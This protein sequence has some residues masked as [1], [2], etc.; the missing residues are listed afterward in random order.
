MIEDRELDA[1]R[2]Q[3]SGVA[4]PSAEFQRDVQRKVQ[5][6]IKRQDRRFVLG[7]ILTVFT[8]FGMLIFA[9]FMR[10]QSSWMGTGWAAG[11]FVLVFIS[12]GCRVW[13]L[14]R[15]WR[16]QSQ[17]TRAFAEL[18]Q[19]RVAARIRLLQIS[20][21]LSFGWIVFCAVLTAANWTTIGRD[22]E[23]HP[24][25]W[26]GVLVACVLMQWPVLW[27]ATAWL[28]RRKLAEL[29]EVKKVARQL[30]ITLKQAKLVLDWRKKLRAKADV[31]A[32]IK[33]VLDELPRVYSTEVYQQKVEAVYQHVFESYSGEGKSI[34]AVT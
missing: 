23:A 31:Y 16:P 22:V 25:A 17:S 32:T 29:S 24:K 18:W 14:R 1:W 11:I 2:E 33:E 3:W 34:Y 19:K 15:T 30:L 9:L 8:F 4:E 12:A 5:Q 13:V 20:I 7:N 27:Y 10:H 26:V 6:K 21:Y 28:R